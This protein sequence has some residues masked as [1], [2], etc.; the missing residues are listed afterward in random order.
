LT[1]IHAIM[2]LAARLMVNSSSPR[3]L[4]NARMVNRSVP[5]LFPAACI[6][7]K[8]FSSAQSEKPRAFGLD[9]SEIFHSLENAVIFMVKDLPIK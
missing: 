2:E 3:R 8:W 5:D 9:A 4:I 7:K 1:F 6:L